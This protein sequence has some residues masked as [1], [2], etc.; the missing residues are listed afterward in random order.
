M[1]D[2]FSEVGCCLVMS[3]NE[4]TKQRGW[5]NKS[6]MAASL[7]ISPQAFDKWG[8]QP[9]KRIGREAFYT[10]A[11]VVE[12]RIQHA[13]R[14]QQPEGEL[15]EGLDPYAEAKL[16]Q[17]RLR[18]TKAQAYAQ[19]QKNQVQDKLLVPVPFATFALAKI[20]AK[21]GSALETVCKTVSRRHPDADPLVMESFE[22]EIA[23]ARNL[24]AEFSDDI[25]GILDE[26]LATLDQ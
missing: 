6:E 8:V 24:S 7:G 19:E 3:K 11:D 17:E 23:L 10:V 20:A 25:P 13:A 15:P 26:Y 9:I 1:Y 12:N 5:L 22:R 14:K 16:T 2:L 21:I 4:T 18:L